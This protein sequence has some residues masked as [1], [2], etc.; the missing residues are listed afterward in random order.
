MPVDQTCG[1]LGFGHSDLLDVVEFILLCFHSHPIA[2]FVVEFLNEIIP[3]HL[4]YIPPHL[5][6]FPPITNIF[7][8]D[9]GST[10][11]FFLIHEVGWLVPQAQLVLQ[12]ELGQ[13]VDGVVL[14]F[15]EQAT[16]GDS[17]FRAPGLPICTVG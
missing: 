4:K 17:A 7:L 2:V 11:H 9:I 5:H 8:H 12:V 10:K 3:C 1:S 14:D 13:L 16:R 15:I 6:S